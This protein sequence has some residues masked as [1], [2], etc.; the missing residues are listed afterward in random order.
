MEIK[1]KLLCCILFFGIIATSNAQFWKKLKEKAKNKLEKKVEEKIDKETDKVLDSAFNGKKKDVKSKEVLKD[2][3]LK[4]YGS[5]SINHSTL[6]GM[7]SVNDLSKTK[8]NKEGNTVSIKG[9]WR[10]SDADVFDGYYIV[11]KNI[12]NIEDLKNKTLKIP[13]EASLKVAYN[14]LVKGKYTYV[15]GQEH[16]P[17]ILQVKSGNVTVSFQKDK[18]ISIN[19][20]GDVNLRNHITAKEM[21]HRTPATINGMFNTTSPEYTI[22]KES[23]Q[24]QKKEKSSNLS[25]SDKAY[26]KEKLSPTVNIPSSFSFNKSIAVEITDNRGDKF[27][28]EFLLGNYPDIY[29]MSVAAEE[30]QGQGQVV[31]VMTPKSSTAFMDV[32][33]MKIKRSTSIEQMGNQYNMNDKLPD[34]TDFEYKKTGNTKTILGYTCEEYRVDYNYTNDKGS[35]SFWVSKDFP[36]QNIEMPLLGMKMNNPYLQGFVL[37]LNSNHQGQNWQIQVKKVS[38]KNVTINTAEYKKMGF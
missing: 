12:N 31:M 20:S 2:N 14:A 5:A 37:E 29:G 16:A 9:S 23:N 24:L 3:R 15:R 6:Y 10:S 28:M 35:A 26:L 33:G 22:T 13:E 27:P 34:G 11:I 36:I 7:F 38:D 17:Q 32:A 21:E 18:N 8:V 30:M 25:N 4:S 1:K 19:F